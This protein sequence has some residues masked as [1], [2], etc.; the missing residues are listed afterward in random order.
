KTGGVRALVG[1]RGEHTF[2]GYNRATQLTAQ[3][4]SSFKP[5]AVYTP[6]LEEGW[7][8]TDVLKDEQMSF[9]HYQP[10]NYDH[11]YAGEVPMY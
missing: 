11:Q 3:P 4:G 8:I 2:R 6:A 10:S 1:G 5:L 7:K 9:G